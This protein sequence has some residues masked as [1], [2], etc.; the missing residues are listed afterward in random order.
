MAVDGKQNR[1][2]PKLRGRDLVKRGYGHS[3]QMK[4]E[5]AEDRKHW[6]VAIRAGTIRVEAEL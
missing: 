3:N 5:M 4:T 6:H 1:S 2:R